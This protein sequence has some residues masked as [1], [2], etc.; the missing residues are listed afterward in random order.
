MSVRDITP[1]LI[2]LQPRMVH[3]RIRLNAASIYGLKK[4]TSDTPF[5][6]NS[7]KFDYIQYE[8]ICV[9]L[10]RFRLGL[11]VSDCLEPRWPCNCT[12]SRTQGGMRRHACITH[13]PR[14]IQSGRLPELIT[15]NSTSR[16]NEHI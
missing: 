8:Y 1:K 14:S 2:D 4:I 11:T 10:H 9:K 7:T 5:P 3:H 13:E 6:S 15:P 12:K 16:Q